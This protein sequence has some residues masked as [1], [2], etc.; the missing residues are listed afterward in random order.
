MDLE[1]GD[2]KDWQAHPDW[3]VSIPGIDLLR[4]VVCTQCPY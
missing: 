1:P 4:A 2:K 3:A